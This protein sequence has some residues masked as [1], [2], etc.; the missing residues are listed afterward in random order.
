MFTTTTNTTTTTTC[1]GFVPPA[2]PLSCLVLFVSR[3]VSSLGWTRAC[4]VASAADLKLSPALSGALSHSVF[5]LTEHF[6]TTILEELERSTEDE[7]ALRSITDDEEGAVVSLHEV[8]MRLL[9]LSMSHQS[10]RQSHYHQYLIIRTQ[11]SNLCLSLQSG[12]RF[13]ARCVDIA[14]AALRR[15][16]S[17]AC[18]NRTPPFEVDNATPL[19]M[20][21]A[22]ICVG[23]VRLL[24]VVV[25]HNKVGDVSLIERY[26]FLGIWQSAELFAL[27]DDSTHFSLTQGY[28]GRRCL[29][30]KCLHSTAATTATTIQ[31]L[32]LTPVLSSTSLIGSL[33]FSPTQKSS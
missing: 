23:F 13:V 29:N 31:S 6:I 25:A 3:H 24:F 10:T 32:L 28:I 2:P 21:S 14:A 8:M 19:S 17:I 33:F 20:P 26:L 5:S 15:R 16:I 12:H 4:L 7:I 11:P 18:P 27:S 1:L 9:Q 22:Q 30:A